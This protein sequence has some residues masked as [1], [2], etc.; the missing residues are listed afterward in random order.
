[1]AWVLRAATI[2]KGYSFPSQALDAKELARGEALIKTLLQCKYFSEEIR[3]VHKGV[4]L[5]STSCLKGLHLF[6]DSQQGILLMSS[7]LGLSELPY[8]K[9]YSFI[10]RRSPHVVALIRGVHLEN[11]HSGVGTTVAIIRQ[12]IWIPGLKGLAVKLKRSCSNCQRHDSR[13]QITPEPPLPVDRA[14]LTAPFSTMGVDH[15]GP[16]YTRDADKTKF[17]ILL[18]TC[19]VIRAVHLELVGSLSTQ[20]TILSFHRFVARRGH[21]NIVYSD[22]SK[23]FNALSRHLSEKLFF[24]QPTWKFITPRAPWVGGWWERLIQ[25]VKKGL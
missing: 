15:A 22:N 20:D 8:D 5:P 24:Y 18:F 14:V 13:S 9:K 1:M 2:F 6:I 3:C 16:L 7:R 10:L 12:R 21:P 19:A 25:S 23:T 17:Y 4:C 11:N